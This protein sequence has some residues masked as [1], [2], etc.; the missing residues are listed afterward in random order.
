MHRRIA[1]AIVRLVLASGLA[2]TGVASAAAGSAVPA[3]AARLEVTETEPLHAIAIAEDERRWGEAA[4]GVY[5]RHADPAVRAR[6]ALATGRLQ[7]STAVPA[8]LPLLADT[9]PEVRQEAVFALGQIGHRSARDALLPLA[10][11]TDPEL[12][13]LAIEALGKLGD[14]AAT[15][16]VVR[17]LD[18]PLPAVRGAAAVALWRLADSTAVPALVA[19]DDDADPQVRWRIFWAMEKVPAP[20]AIDLRAALHLDDPEPLVRAHAART[21]GREKSPRGTAYLLN[22]LADP[23]EAVVVNAIRALQLAGDTTCAA[24][25]PE[26]LKRLSHAHPCVRVTAAAA[27]GERFVWVAADSTVRPRLADS[28]IAHLGDPD[29]ATRGAAAKALLARRGV[30]ALDAVRPLLG[31]A[32]VYVRVAVLESFR[33]LPAGGDAARLLREHLGPGSALF[34]RATAAEVMGDRRDAGAEALLRAGLADTSVLFVAS[35]A[36]GLA[37]LGD[38]ASVPALVALYAA[39]AADHEPDARL[40]ILDALRTL[41]RT[42]A[43]DSLDHAIAARQPAPATHDDAFFATPAER[44]AVIHT[45]KG[46]IEWAFYGREAPQTVRNFVALA[47]RGY[48]DGDAVHRVVP[49]FVIQDGDPTGTGSGGPGYTIRCE[50][51]RLRYA[52]AMVGMALSGKDTGGSQWFITLS[53]QPHLDGRYTIF[54]HVVRG[55]DVA[56]RI[57]Q[58]DRIEKVEILR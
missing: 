16:V 29:A 2:A 39:R 43:A 58:G 3:R 19:H 1:A 12:R 50:Y 42:A 49:D 37:A 17:A 5:L 28:L 34:E 18:D 25:A 20:D 48:F 30:A 9:S 8:L 54:A 31:D 24:C 33:G 21:I 52:A 14:K 57:V 55:M 53:P 36:A 56:R 7:D 15:P 38:T 32:S 13:G 27:L 4:L 51:N 10:A 46:D 22:A 45:S 6:A 35:C 26:L 47:R 44:G 23:D 40:A 11:A 41:G